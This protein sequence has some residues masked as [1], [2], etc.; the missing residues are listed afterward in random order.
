MAY[1]TLTMGA[2]GDDVK[3]L[4]RLLKGA[5]YALDEDGVYGARTQEAVKAYQ[6]AHNLAQSGDAGASTW[7]K[8]AANALSA[9]PQNLSAGGSVK[10]LEQNRP[11]AYASD[12]AG[13]I[14]ELLDKVLNRE[15]FSYSFADDELYKRY[16]DQ[17]NYLGERA[18]NDARG[19]ASA[20]SGGYGNSFAESAGQQAYQHY[21]Q[22]LTGGIPELYS[23][24]LSAYD[25]ETSRLSDALSTLTQAEKSAYDRYRDDLEAYDDALKYYYKKM[26]DEQAQAE[27]AQKSASNKSSG[28]AKSAVS[29]PQTQFNAAY[30]LT[31]SEFARRKAAKAPSLE[32]YSDYAQ[33]VAAMKRQ[34]G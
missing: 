26:R 23:L 11:K 30:L 20:L 14:D 13:Q 4:Q 16:R 19:G 15:E 6:R 25:A 24:A 17:Y 3:T 28:A 27:R 31:P 8:L 29:E 12:Y 33:Y 18:M 22:Q 5:G 9:L 32:Q 2:R 7:A 1:A 10:Y 34:Y 21:L